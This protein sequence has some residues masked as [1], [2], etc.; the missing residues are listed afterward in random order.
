MNQGL[1]T[2]MSNLSLGFF[3][4]ADANKVAMMS[5]LLEA[6]D[7]ALG[8]IQNFIDTHQSVIPANVIKARA[9]V[10]EARTIAKL[11]MNIGALVMAHP[12]EDLKVLYK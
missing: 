1:I 11:T 9:M 3:C 6:K 7:Y 8:K 2:N 12:S 4:M 10:N 5:D